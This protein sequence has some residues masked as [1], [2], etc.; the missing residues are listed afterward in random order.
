MQ[1]LYLLADAFMS[2]IHVNPPW[3]LGRL[4][5]M[6]PKIASKTYHFYQNL[7]ISLIW[8][9]FSYIYFL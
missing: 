8:I 9:E 3:S 1:T 7:E 4:S 2:Q 6:I 5:E